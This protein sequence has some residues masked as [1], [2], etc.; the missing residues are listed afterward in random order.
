MFCQKCG[1]TDLLTGLE[2]DDKDR[3]QLCHGCGEGK[4]TKQSRLY[5]AEW[6]K[7]R[8]ET[9]YPKTAAGSEYLCEMSAGDKAA[10]SVYQPMT[11]VTKNSL[12]CMKYR[13]ESISVLPENQHQVIS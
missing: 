7:V 3:L 4:V 1:S 9:E 11:T 5:D 10:I 13:Q 6:A 2:V 12:N 8:P